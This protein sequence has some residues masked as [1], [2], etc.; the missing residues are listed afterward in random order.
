MPRSAT[1]TGKPLSE[2]ILNHLVPDEA[3]RTAILNGKLDPAQV[4]DIDTEEKFEAAVD[5]MAKEGDPEVQATPIRWKRIFHPK[6]SAF[7]EHAR[8]NI[9]AIIASRSG[10]KDDADSASQPKCQK[11]TLIKASDLQASIDTLKTMGNNPTKDNCCGGGVLQ[12]GPLLAQNGTASISLCSAEKQCMGCGD[13]AGVMDGMLKTCVADGTLTGA[14][15][16][17]EGRNGLTYEVGVAST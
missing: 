7:N 9:D 12:C 10:G 1:D 6:G 4:I 16:T 3:N 14:S 13:L 5:N 8:V 17:I 15:G 11:G 2:L